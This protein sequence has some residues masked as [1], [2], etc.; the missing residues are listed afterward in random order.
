MAI[1]MKA[2]MQP[3]FSS[4][5]NVADLGEETRFYESKITLKVLGY[6]VGANKNDEQPHIVIRENAVDVKT[7]RERVVMGDE[8]DWGPI[9]TPARKISVIIIPLSF[10]AIS[11]YLL[12]TFKALRRKTHGT[13]Q[14]QICITGNSTSRN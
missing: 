13:K 5:N 7:P 12:E 9:G 11:Y 2:F 3:D 6:L 14:I 10:R 1:L 4:E 8:P